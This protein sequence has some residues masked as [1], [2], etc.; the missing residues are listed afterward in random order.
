MSWMASNKSDRIKYSMQS[1]IKHSIRC[2][3]MCLYVSLFPVS[4]FSFSAF[5]FYLFISTQNEVWERKTNGHHIIITQVKSKIWNFS[6]CVPRSLS[7]SRHSTYRTLFNGIEECKR[8]ESAHQYD[9]DKNDGRTRRENEITI[10]YDW[11]TKNEKK[12][13]LRSLR[14][15]SLRHQQ[16]LKTTTTTSLSFR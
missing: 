12:M 4:F 14:Y 8:N 1:E 9:D 11:E 6:L 3:Y 5:P 10:K 7:F 2:A 15:I 13:C 16:W